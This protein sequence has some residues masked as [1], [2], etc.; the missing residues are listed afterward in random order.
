MFMYH[1]CWVNVY[2]SK[3]IPDRIQVASTTKTRRRRTS[4]TQDR[5]RVTSRKSPRKKG[6]PTKTSP[7]TR[8]VT[9]R[10]RAQWEAHLLQ[11]VCKLATTFTAQA[12]AE[13][14]A[15]QAVLWR[16]TWRTMTYAIHG[17]DSVSRKCRM[18]TTT[19][20]RSRTPVTTHRA[21]TELSLWW[22]TKLGRERLCQDTVRLCDDRSCFEVLP[23]K[24]NH[25]LEEP[26]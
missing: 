4:R 8:T 13:V 11:V 23:S 19:P 22:T 14:A 5:K 6:V 9:T 21:W 7:R 2:F 20:T 25:V 15:S 10:T 1:M 3:G 24:T 26:A 16:H 18:R 17:S 12:R